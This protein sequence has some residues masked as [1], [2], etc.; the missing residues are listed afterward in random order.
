MIEAFRFF[1]LILFWFSV[2]GIF[3]GLIR[4]VFVVWFLARFN[5]MT[6]IRVYG[7]IALLFAGLWVLLGIIKNQM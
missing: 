5:R 7:C 4:P 1:V 3:F 2:T 6:V